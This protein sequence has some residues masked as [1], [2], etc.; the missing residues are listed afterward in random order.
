MTSADLL[1]V[2]DDVLL[3]RGLMRALSLS[4]IGVRHVTRCA[5]A[6]ALTGP[7]A[8]GIFDIDLPDGDGVDLARL[9]RRRGV[10]T[11]PVFYTACQSPLRLERA[12]LIG[13]VFV[14]SKSLAPL[15]E[16]LQRGA[17]GV[18]TALFAH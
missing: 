5:T 17:E 4:G 16:Q 3:A 11:R 10:V 6:A 9:L 15:V 14:K 1:L 13:P 7:F 8:A 12:R 18:S 2:E